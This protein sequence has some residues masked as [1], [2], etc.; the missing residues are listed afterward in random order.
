VKRNE[1]CK[2]GKLCGDLAC[3]VRPFEKNARGFVLVSQI[4]ISQ[5]NKKQIGLKDHIN[6]VGYKADARDNGV[7]L[8]YCP[9]CGEKIDWFRGRIDG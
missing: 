1:K 8:N 3:L 2:K 4:K 7:M 9:F 5:L 6:G